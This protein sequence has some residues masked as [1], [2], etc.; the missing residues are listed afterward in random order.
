VL[1]GKKAKWKFAPGKGR[2]QREGEAQDRG[3]PLGNSKKEAL[4][5]SIGQR[6]ARKMSEGGV[7]ITPFAGQKDGKRPK[8]K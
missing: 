5:R 4:E 7:R 8:L 3:L 2:K 6:R 1:T